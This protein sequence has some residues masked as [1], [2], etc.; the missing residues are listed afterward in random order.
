M[1]MTSYRIINYFTENWYEI[2]NWD[3]RLSIT[4][5][6]ILG[7]FFAIH[8]VWSPKKVNIYFSILHFMCMYY[9]YFVCILIL[10]DF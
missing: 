6:G 2:R 9:D 10:M 8:L 1:I 4:L 3:V 5:F 7:L